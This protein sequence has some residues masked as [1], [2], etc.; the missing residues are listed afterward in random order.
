MALT[1][2]APGQ[3]TR[4]G[5]SALRVR[6]TSS[7]RT[8]VRLDFTAASG[9]VQR[10]SQTEIVILHSASVVHV[11]VLPAE[12]ATFPEQA[13]AGVSVICEPI[14]TGDQVL[15]RESDVAGLRSAQLVLVEVDAQVLVRA[16]GP[17]QA[18]E[19]MQPGVAALA[20]SGVDEPARF[21]APSWALL[22]DGS[23]SMLSLQADG[24]LTDLLAVVCGVSY[25]TCSGLPTRALITSADRCRDVTAQLTADELDISAL[26]DQ[27][28]APW[29]ALEPGVSEL[30][31][32]TASIV[33]VTDGIPPDLDRL[34]EQV[35]QS[36]T[37]LVLVTLGQARTRSTA[38]LMDDLA[39]LAALQALDNA[40]VVPVPRTGRE[41][42]P[43]IELNDVT[44][45]G[46]AAKL[47][48]TRDTVPKQRE[49]WSR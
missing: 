36:G 9:S 40:Q 16:T 21:N 49:G 46:L 26:L 30:L 24:Q 13:M 8:P 18:P 41:D 10:I 48:A 1:E 42:G 2:L 43:V 5:R 31:D 14:A 29:G 28:P 19:W 27:P 23:A 7:T 45:Q 20:A 15:I 33:A 22:L 47:A 25:Q 6:A 37:H 3:E 32:L 11:S 38:A 12:G 44:R 17:Q 4:L 34:I 39:P 35:Q